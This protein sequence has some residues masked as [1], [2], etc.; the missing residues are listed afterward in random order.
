MPTMAD[1]CFHACA[2]TSEH[3]HANIPKLMLHMNDDGQYNH[4]ATRTVIASVRC[5][6]HKTH[7]PGDTGNGMDKL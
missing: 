3:V 4:T 2:T 1:A 6:L 5:I 7:N